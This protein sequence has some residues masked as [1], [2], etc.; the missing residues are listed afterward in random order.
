MKF[1]CS[2][3]DLNEALR[4]VS[5]AIAT[6]PQTPILSC[7]FIQTKGDE[8]EL[9]ATNYELSFI[10]HIPAT[11]EESGSIALTG[12]YVL[13]V[14]TKMPGDT[15]TFSMMDDDKTIHIQSGQSKFTLLSMNA[16]E[17]PQIEHLAGNI[18]FTL[19]DNV[20]RELIRKTIFA[21]ATDEGRPVFTGCALTIEGNR[22][23]MAAT[24][25]HR[26]AVI[27]KVFNQEIGS[28]QIIIPAK[29]LA[30]V[31]HMPGGDIP[32][33]VT[34]T[35]SYNQIS[36]S[37]PSVY[38][39]SRLIEGQ[40]PS[41]TNVIP[42][43]FATNVQVDRA[44]F[45]AAIDRVALISRAGDYNVVKLQF[46][47]GN[48]HLH[49]RNPEIGDADEDVPAEIDGPDLM[50]A[51]NANYLIDVMKSMQGDVCRIG[52]NKELSPAVL[53]EPDDEDFLYVVTPVRTA[54]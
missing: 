46:S 17:F 47:N 23:T 32:T 6:K 51:F 39:A 53:R 48:I 24:N 9:Q 37:T 54:H 16:A 49:S 34:L 29:I 5:K 30:E 8:L 44:A 2:K 35:C 28:I 26:L 4:I 10:C 41:F 22:V 20:L 27:S 42:H 14:V 36:F 33:E 3:N 25:I 21:C 1:T 50:I 45:A 43:S 52:L 38:M 18:Q 13:E 15:I 40:F 19:K 12:R 11:I 7:I 31:L